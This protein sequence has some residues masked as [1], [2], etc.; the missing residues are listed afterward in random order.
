MLCHTPLILTWLF[1]FR[2][3]LVY[4]VPPSCF[5]CTNITDIVTVFESTIPI[6]FSR[7]KN[8]KMKMVGF[9]WPFSFLI[10]IPAQKIPMVHFYNKFLHGLFSKVSFLKGSIC[11][12]YGSGDRLLRDVATQHH[13]CPE[14][15]WLAM[16]S[17]HVT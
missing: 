5:W 15:C 14:L 12:I 9:F 3:I 13:T 1:D 6:P 11:Q 7:R 10:K 17:F 4:S 16:V 2:P 8:M